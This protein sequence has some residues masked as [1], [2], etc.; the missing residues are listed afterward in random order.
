MKKITYVFA[1]LLASGAAA[2]AQT[3]A[4]Y[5]DG[6]RYMNEVFTASTKT[7]DVTYGQNTTYTGTNQVLK[8]D[9]YEPTGD[10]A[11]ARPLLILAHGGSFIGGTKTDADMAYFGP[12][13]AQRGFVVAS[14][15]YRLGLNF[16]SLDS[17][18]VMTA[19]VRAVHD[20]RACIRYFRQDVQT[21]GNTYKID[22]NMIIIGGSSA[23]A[24]TAL[25]TA[26][27]D[28]MSETPQYLQDIITELGGG[29]EGNSGNPGYSSIPNGV[30]NGSGCLGEKTWLEANDIP[31][32][33]VHGTADGTVPYGTA[34]QVL[35]GTG[36]EVSVVDG[37]GTLHPYALSTGTQSTLKTFNGGG[38]VPY[39]N[40]GPYMDTTMAYFSTFLYERI[41][42]ATSIANALPKGMVKMYPNPAADIVSF[43]LNIAEADLT[44]YDLAGKVMLANTLSE[45]TQDLNI[46]TLPAGI[47]IVNV[48]ANGKQYSEKLVVR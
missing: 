16:F 17:V 47:Y 32:V 21:N 36:V 1:L 25:H 30:M 44:I 9:I 4:A 40:G 31:L 6:N 10:N 11:V 24:I 41:C 22:P 7:A 27:L 8:M 26:Y 48:N 29:V 15:N 23:G 3:A 5:C 20:M 46:A 19:V 33:S 45:G 13:F 38:H 39:L 12:H 28:K 34:M 37:S 43:E 2:F 35:P 14:I 42:Y 18:E